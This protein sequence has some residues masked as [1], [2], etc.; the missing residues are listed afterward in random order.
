MESE[1]VKQLGKQ[2]DI[3]E[4]YFTNLV[5]KAVEN[6]SKYGDVEKFLG[7]DHEVIA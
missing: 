5:D 1:M 7:D 2:D 6:M 3:D 4:S